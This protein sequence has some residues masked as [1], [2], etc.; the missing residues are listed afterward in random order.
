MGMKDVFSRTTLHAL[1]HAVE[2]TNLTARIFWSIVFFLALG[3]VSTHITFLILRYQRHDV[4]TT[5]STKFG[6]NV[7][8]P[9]IYLTLFGQID[10][11]TVKSD[12]SSETVLAG[13]SYSVFQFTDWTNATGNGLYLDVNFCAAAWDDLQVKLEA[14]IVKL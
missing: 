8:K 4:S 13:K 7:T 10:S 14:R 1:P 11:I 5:Y 12:F 3:F 6:Q 9:I 2:A